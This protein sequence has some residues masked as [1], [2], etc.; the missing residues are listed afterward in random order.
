MEHVFVI[1]D[2]EAMRLGIVE[3]LKRE[4][5]FVTAFD[6]GP[7][8]IKNVRLNHAS[9]AII[10]LKMEPID[11]I[12]I[13][14]QLKEINNQLEV[15]MI[16]A[17]GTV[18]IAVSAIR[19]GAFDF[20]TKPFSPEELRLRVNRIAVKLKQERIIDD[21]REQNKLLTE[22]LYSG[23][24]ELIGNSAEIKKI[25]LLIEQV[26]KTDSTIIIHG[27]SGTGKELVAHAIH[28]KSDRKEKPF[29]KVNCGALNDNLLESELF[30]HEKGS[31]TGAIKQR[32]GRFELADGGTLF[33]D[34]I[35]DISLAMQVKL[36]RVLQDG[37]FER[38]GGETSIKTNVRIISATNKDL[39]MLIKEGK[40][41]EDLYYRLSV[42]PIEI[43]SLRNRMEDIPLLAEYFLQK[44][45]A[46]NKNISKRISQSGMNKLINYNWP[47]NIRELENFIERLYVISPGDKIEDNLII[48]NSDN[49]LAGSINNSLPLEEAVNIFERNLIIDA[50]KK[51]DGVKNRA[52]K[53]LG[54]G[55]S[56]LYYKLEKHGLL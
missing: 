19:L 21:L 28:K 37:E 23:F 52:A 14:K 16:S 15:L 10:D 11:G 29:I 3:S 12:E 22:E 45:S 43:P 30:G 34:E 55:T 17:Y 8:A 4:G 42:I 25:F 7:E 36:L 33:L 47:G 49:A 35:G 38:V 27:E 5:Y 1:E 13:L 2:N 9:I 53:L 40:F 56:V 46:K 39:K 44:C 31:F 24:D 26:S 51:A 50:M 6:N 20:L 32:R 41:R 54:I 48:L 18:E